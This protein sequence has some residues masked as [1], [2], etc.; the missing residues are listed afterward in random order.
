MTLSEA[1]PMSSEGIGS[2]QAQ[3]ID[4]S[5]NSAVEAVNAEVPA[6]APPGASNDSS[7]EAAAALAAANAAAVAKPVE[8]PW[9]FPRLVRSLLPGRGQRAKSNPEI[10]GGGDGAAA[11]ASLLDSY[12][13]AVVGVSAGADHTVAITA[14]GEMYSW[15]GVVDSVDVQ[16]DDGGDGD[17]R[18]QSLNDGKSG[19]AE[20]S[21]LNGRSLG[22]LGDGKVRGLSNVPRLVAC[23]AQSELD[24]IQ[25]QQSIAAERDAKQSSKRGGQRNSA[26]SD[27]S[28]TIASLSQ[29]R[30]TSVACG[31]WHTLAG[32]FF[33]SSM[34]KKIHMACFVDTTRP[35][36]F[37]V[38]F[39]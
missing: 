6:S 22:V 37:V 39:F 3:M 20:L 29:R 25:I 15:G 38:F 36:S 14:A 5:L 11:A 23:T 27:S 30:V 18:E 28:S 12:H 26:G 24:R 9:M 31:G 8:Q 7:Q 17:A 32:A 13:G 19:R 35:Y 2:Q 1:T 4:A 33:S 34:D 16:Q 10:G 21:T